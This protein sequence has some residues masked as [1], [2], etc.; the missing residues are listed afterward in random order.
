MAW[1]RRGNRCYYYRKV[2]RGRRVVSEYAGE[3][4]ALLDAEERRERAQ[5]REVER[6]TRAEFE[7][8]QRALGDLAELANALTRAVLL[9]SGYHTHKG[10][11]R[12][13]RGN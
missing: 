12:R 13:R 2:R 7:Q 9:A 8:S 1:E 4:G 5:A 11:W 3:L 10:Q 6:Q